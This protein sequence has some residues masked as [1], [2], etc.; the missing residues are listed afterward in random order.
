[1]NTSETADDD[2]ETTQIPR[3][4]GGMLTGRAFAIIVVPNDNP[5]DIV[6][7]IVGCDSGNASPF[8]RYLVL[9]VVGFAVCSV[10]GT[11]QA[12]F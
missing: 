4:K 5:L 6:I 9:G 8:S 12:V 2:G 10:D 11:N 1:M 3:L 7:A